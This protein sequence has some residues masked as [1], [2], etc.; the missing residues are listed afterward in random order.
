MANTAIQLKKSVVSGNTPYTL[1]DGEVAINTADGV[2]FYKSPSNV[3]RTIKN[4]N[5]FSTVNVNSTLLLSTSP[6]DILS[7]AGNNGITVLGNSGTDTITINVNNGTTSQK[8]VVQLYDGVDSNSIT[9]AAT[10]NSVNSVYALAYAAFNK[11]SGGTQTGVLNQKVQE[12]V[13]SNNQ[14]TFGVTG[15]YE[16][17]NIIVYV[18]GVLLSNTDYSATNSSDVVLYVP[19]SNNDIISICKWYNSYINVST[20]SSNTINFIDGQITTITSITGATTP[21]QVLDIFSTTDYRTVKYLIQ[22]SSSTDYQ[23]S[24][25]VLIHN[26]TNAYISEYGLVTTSGVLMNYDADISSGSVRLLM[27]PVNSINTIKLLKTSLIV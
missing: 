17:S 3:I 18:N 27:N 16:P 14:T 22:V 24:E 11:S 1:L 19:T 4:T 2:L 6:D 13:A 7:F 23:S 15:G 20:I 12:I 25:I 26:G 8:G 10:A 5:S 9:L 21:N